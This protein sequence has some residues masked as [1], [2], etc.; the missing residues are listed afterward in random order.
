[1]K[2]FKEL[3]ESILADI[4]DTIEGGDAAVQ[5]ALNDEMLSMFNMDKKTKYDNP[6]TAF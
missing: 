4:D 1:M 5:K 3:Q 6:A 2:D